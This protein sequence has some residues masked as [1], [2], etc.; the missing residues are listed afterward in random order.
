MLRLKKKSSL[1]CMVSGDRL[2]G[3][4]A[5]QAPSPR[6]AFVDPAAV[7]AEAT[8][9]AV[10]LLKDFDPRLYDSFTCCSSSSR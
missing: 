3:Q 6:T 1:W 9:S 4:P 8:G 7:V 2:A 10:A 5:S